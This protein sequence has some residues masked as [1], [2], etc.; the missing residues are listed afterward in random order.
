MK[1]TEIINWLQVVAVLVS[2]GKTTYDEIA[3]IILKQNGQT[4]TE[5]AAADDAQLA[6]LHALIAQ[7][8][9]ALKAGQ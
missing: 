2:L 5:T 7:A 4:D 6:L 9:T 3:G 1:P 8:R